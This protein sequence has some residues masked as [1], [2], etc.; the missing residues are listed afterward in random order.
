M[1]LSNKLN[2]IAS[3]ESF[4]GNALYQA[5]EL[6]DILTTE[7]K[8]MLHRYMHGSE[9]TADRFRLQDLVIKLSAIGQ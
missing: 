3:G 4:Y 9:L 1:K 6:D 7:D 2:A 5:I 8:R